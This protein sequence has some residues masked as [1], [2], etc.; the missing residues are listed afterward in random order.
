VQ[1][2]MSLAPFLR[3]AARVHLNGLTRAY[4]D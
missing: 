3:D 4:L 1:V 2:M